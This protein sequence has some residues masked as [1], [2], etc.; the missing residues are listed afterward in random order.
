[1]QQDT[2]TPCLL[3][4]LKFGLECGGSDGFSGITANPLLG[5]FSDYVI[6]HG[7]TSVLT[8][9]PEMFGAERILMSRCHDET[10]FDKTVSMVN[11][12]KQYFI[13]HHQPIYENPSPGNKAGGIS[14][15]EEKSL[16]CTQK[17]GQS[18]VID[19]LKYGDRLTRHGFN[20]LSAP[21]NDALPPAHWPQ[22][23]VTWYCSALGV[24]RPTADSFQL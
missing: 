16:G 23:V 5:Q 19:V 1:M 14:T 11:D 8:E 6:Q 20:L 17:A 2:R 10:T 12:F 22:P 4:E 24:V 9:V 21:G 3:S 13:D 15:L 18:Q 7:G